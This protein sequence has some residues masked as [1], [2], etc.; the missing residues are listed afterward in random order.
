MDKNAMQDKPGI[1][2]NK[3]ITIQMS[4]PT[5]PEEQDHHQMMFSFDI[6]EEAFICRKKEEKAKRLKRLSDHKSVHLN[7]QQE[8]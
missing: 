4:L 5:T 2:R 6:S 8:Q 1:S 7:D 3:T